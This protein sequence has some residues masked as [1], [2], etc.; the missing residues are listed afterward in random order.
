[1]YV[2]L[3]S[4]YTSAF[5]EEYLKD[6]SKNNEVL[7]REETNSSSSGFHHRPD[8]PIIEAICF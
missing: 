7:K 4:F 6:N 3:Q 1:M 8:K 5:M 2:Y